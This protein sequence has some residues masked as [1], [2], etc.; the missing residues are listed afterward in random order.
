M[1]CRLSQILV[2]LIASFLAV[3][4]LSARNLGAAPF[5]QENRPENLKALWELILQSYYVKNDPKTAVALLR[6]SRAGPEPHPEGP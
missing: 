2:F 5:L 6:G 4:L 3:S 1:R